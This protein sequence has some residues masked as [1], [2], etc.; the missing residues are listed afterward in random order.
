METETDPADKIVDPDKVLAKQLKKRL[1][2]TNIKSDLEV[3][4]AMLELA[5]VSV[6][7]AMSET[8]PELKKKRFDEALN[9]FDPT[10]LRKRQSLQE[11]KDF[12]VPRTGQYFPIMSALGRGIVLSYQDQYEKSNAEFKKII[13]A[14]QKIDLKPKQVGPLDA[15]LW[16]YD[17]WKRLVADALDRNAKN[18]GVAQLEEPLNRY[19]MYSPK[20]HEMK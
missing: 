14:Q 11:A 5:M 12:F 4:N 18:M 8:S 20:I 3:T 9:L 7:G 16:K 2:E 1:D 13:L 17:R 10:S 15:F 6:R 19:R